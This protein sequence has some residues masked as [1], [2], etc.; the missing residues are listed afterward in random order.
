[1]G[2]YETEENLREQL[3]ILDEDKAWVY[4]GGCIISNGGQ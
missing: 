3:G 2:G 1:M 4:N